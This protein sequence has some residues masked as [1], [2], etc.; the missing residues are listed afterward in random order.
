MPKYNLTIPNL[1]EIDKVVNSLE[2]VVEFADKFP[3]LP[4]SFKPIVDEALT[5]LTAVQKALGQTD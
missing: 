2:D 4:A 5:V 1:A 3:F